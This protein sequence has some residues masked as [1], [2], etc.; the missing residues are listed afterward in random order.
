MIRRGFWLVTGAALGVAGYRKAARVTR[1]LTGQP[2][3]A[4]PV[5]RPGGRGPIS[6]PWPVRLAVGARGAAGF[7]RDVRDG[8]TEYY[9]GHD[10]AGGSDPGAVLPAAPYRALHGPEIGRSLGIRSL[11]NSGDQARPG[12]SQQSPRLP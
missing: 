4:R 6:R 7:V 10:P 3:G 5:Q 12:L 9:A 11:E 1:A 8:M 2:A